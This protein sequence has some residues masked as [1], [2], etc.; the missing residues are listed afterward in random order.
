VWPLDNVVD[1]LEPSKSR[2][3]DARRRVP[4]KIVRKIEMH[5]E[6]RSEGEAGRRTRPAAPEPSP[7]LRV[8]D[9]AVEKRDSCSMTA[10]SRESKVVQAV[11]WHQ[12]DQHPR[13]RELV[14]QIR[15]R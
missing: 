13:I 4:Q 14:I 15:E 12:D 2:T 9:L 10:R 3:V 6:V 1:V 7:V 11:L 5:G 8:V